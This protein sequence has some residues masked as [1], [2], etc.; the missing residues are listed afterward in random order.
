MPIE[1]LYQKAYA[2]TSQITKPI[3]ILYVLQMPH[4]SFFFPVPHRNG[5]ISEVTQ[6]FAHYMFAYVKSDVSLGVYIKILSTCSI[7]GSLINFKFFLFFCC[8][9]IYSTIVS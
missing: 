6:N 2:A 4:K 9:Y 1:A 8:F 7:T 3:P 5:H